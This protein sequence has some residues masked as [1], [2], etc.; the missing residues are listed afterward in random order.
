MNNLG[1]RLDLFTTA[2][3]HYAK[4]TTEFCGSQALLATAIIDSNKDILVFITSYTL[5]SCQ[6]PYSSLL[7]TFALEECE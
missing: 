4:C 7:R 2:G 5:L 3:P 6:L 1:A